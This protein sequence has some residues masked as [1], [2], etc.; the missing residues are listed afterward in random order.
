MPRHVLSTVVAAAT[1]RSLTDIA[2][3]KDDWGIST[4]A[5]DAF[6]ARSIIRCSS[7]AENF[8][9]RVFALETV[10]DQIA[11]RRDPWPRM[12]EERPDLLQ[13][14]RWPIVAITSVT[15]DG[16][17]LVEGTDF[18]TDAKP[19]QL[20]RLNEYGNAR[21]WSGETIV[22]I[23]S[24]GYVLPG[25]TAVAGAQNLPDDINDAVSRMV[26]TRYAERQRDPLVKSEYVDGVGRTEY[27]APT[28]ASNLSPDVEDILDNYRVPVV[29]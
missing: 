4:S 24:A 10:Q 9:N 11:L 15:V 8:C 6:I 5:D 18:L 17:T 27:L 1:L 20:R 2:T 25:A 16:T 29:I 7:S 23:Y 28:G 14:S 21:D 12:I 13:L 3:V 26:Y 19:G 22:V